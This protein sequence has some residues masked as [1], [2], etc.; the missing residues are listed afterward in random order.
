MKLS[1]HLLSIMCAAFVFAA[2]MPAP[3][4][5]TGCTT[6]TGNAGDQIYNPTYSVM[7]YCNGAN[8][9]NM[10]TGGGFGTLTPS[11]LCNSD[12][13][14]INCTAQSVPVANGGTG[15]TSLT[16]H[17]VLIGEGASAVTSSVGTANNILQGNGS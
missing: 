6:P 5:A 10:G 14:V 12:G 3:A 1:R 4:L 17:G 2:S 16:A 15:S 11:D 7:Q 8:W 9:V 13:T